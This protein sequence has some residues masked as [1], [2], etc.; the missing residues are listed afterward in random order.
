MDKK[1]LEKLRDELQDLILR[2]G[3]LQQR[4]IAAT[5][6]KFVITRVRPRP[7]P[8]T[9][10]VIRINYTPAEGQRPHSPEFPAAIEFEGEGLA[11]QY[12]ADYLNENPYDPNIYERVISLYESA[13]A[14]EAEADAADFA[15]WTYE[16]IKD[17]RKGG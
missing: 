8:D 1:E 9:Q 3:R 11:A 7:K 13:K 15:D 10:D 5:G 14:K 16:N 2:V 6:Q 4:H 17:R 12:V